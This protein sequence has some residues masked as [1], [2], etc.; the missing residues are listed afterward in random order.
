M[1]QQGIDV[2]HLEVGEPDFGPP[3]C[4][5]RSLET[6]LNAGYAKYTE[7]AGISVLRNAISQKLSDQHKY[8]IKPDQIIVTPGGR[9]G[10]FLAVSNEIAP[11]DEVIIIDPSYP[12][13]SDLVKTVGGRPIHL[14]TYLE[15][16]WNPDCN[17]LECLVNDTTSMIIL[18][19]P[20]NP[21]GKIFSREN[22]L[23]IGDIARAHDFMVLIDDPYSCFT[24]E[25]SDRYFNLASVA[26]LSDNVAYLFS[27][28]KAYAMSGW[29]LG[30]TVLP[31]GLK[32]QLIK[33]HDMNMICAP[34]VSQ[35][36]GIAALSSDDQH[37]DAYRSAF[38][39]RR[40]L[41]CQRLDA[42]AHVFSYNKPEGA[43]YVFPK[44]LADHANSRDF[45]LELLNKTG[46]ALAPGSA[47]GP[48]GENHVRMAYCVP[49][50][51]I[52][53]AFDR[54]ETHFGKA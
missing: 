37:L 18:N 5:K 9:F 51:T 15:D 8:E 6:A 10:L 19:S 2:L 12:A 26:E 16:G 50:E 22:L 41:I 34:R 11:G 25:N 31:A 46:V 21:T 49:D 38:S 1:E 17:H 24:Y 53:Q 39:R 28:S 4:V 45:C 54:M 30:Y 20:S 52:E 14:P 29:R 47:F 36:A 23:R 42:L 27:F 43:Y 13:Y 3:E 33:V 32:R 7:T 48:S 40:E 44:I 35:A